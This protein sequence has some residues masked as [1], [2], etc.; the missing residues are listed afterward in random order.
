MGNKPKSSNL[1]G[2]HTSLH[3][4]TL[5]TTKLKI[6]KVITIA[7]PHLRIYGRIPKFQEQKDAVSDLN[8]AVSGL[9]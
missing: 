3:F 4:K 6:L 1:E 5:P 8:D 2:S 9:V 7:I